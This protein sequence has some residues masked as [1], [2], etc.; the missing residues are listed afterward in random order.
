MLSEN[1]IKLFGL[2]QFL[3][4]GRERVNSFTFDPMDMMQ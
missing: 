4:V 3:W 1:S 2:D